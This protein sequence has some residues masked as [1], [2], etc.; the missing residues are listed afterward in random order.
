M[1]MGEFPFASGYIACMPAARTLREES[2]RS[3]LYEFVG[4]PHW[5]CV[6]VLWLITEKT[7]RNIERIGILGHVSQVFTSIHASSN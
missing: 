5:D 6:M 2:S 3:V 4:G 1:E 7:C